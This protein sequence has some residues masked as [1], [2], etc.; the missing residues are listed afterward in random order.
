M[1]S[2]ILYRTFPFRNEEKT[3]YIRV[4]NVILRSNQGLSTSVQSKRNPGPTQAQP[5]QNETNLWL[6]IHLAF[7]QGE[8]PSPIPPVTVRGFLSFVV[9]IY[10][11]Y[12][13][14]YI[15]IKKKTNKTWHWQGGYGRIG[16]WLGE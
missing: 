11:L 15:Y 14:I 10:I 8:Y 13:Y 2:I 12:I 9:N 4:R 5:T 6:D 7:P 16:E 3:D 1:G